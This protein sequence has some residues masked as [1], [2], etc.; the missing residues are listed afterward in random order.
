MTERNVNLLLA[1]GAQPTN[2]IATDNV[3]QWYGGAIK[4]V[5]TGVF[6][7]ATA[8]VMFCTKFPPGGD[9]ADYAAN[10]GN[11]VWVSL[12]EF[13]EAGEYVLENLN[14]CV[15]AINV[16]NSGANTRAKVIILTGEG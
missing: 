5:A 4:L 16:T 6:D 9:R 11:Y 15:L 12:H 8:E 13:T 2:G 10:P 3:H 1:D 14:P 7:G